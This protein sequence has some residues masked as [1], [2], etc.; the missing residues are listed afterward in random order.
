MRQVLVGGGWFLQIE[1][2]DAGG[3]VGAEAEDVEGLTVLGGVVLGV[4]VD[5]DTVGDV[6]DGGGLS[7][8]RKKQRENFRDFHHK[9][10]SETRH[11]LGDVKKQKHKAMHIGGIK[12]TQIPSPINHKCKEIR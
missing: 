7:R 6:F 9:K 3:R 10:L 4:A 1:V 11:T 12:L 2:E 8:E 5:G